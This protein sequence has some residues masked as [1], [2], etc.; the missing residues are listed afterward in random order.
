VYKTGCPLIFQN[1]HL[2][3]L[4]PFLGERLLRLRRAGPS[5]SLDKSAEQKA[6]WLW[7]DNITGDKESQTWKRFYYV[8][9]CYNIFARII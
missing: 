4:A 8:G 5:A 1:I 6:I 9:K 2:P 3:E 7:R